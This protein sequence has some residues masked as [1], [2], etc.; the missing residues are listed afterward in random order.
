MLLKI[1]NKNKNRIKTKKN[2]SSN[3]SVNSTQKSMQKCILILIKAVKRHVAL[4]TRHK[5]FLASNEFYCVD[6]FLADD[7]ESTH[8]EI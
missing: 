7:W 1:T 2:V 5:R 4:K 6:D 8:F 3:K